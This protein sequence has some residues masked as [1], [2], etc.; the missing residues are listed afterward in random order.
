VRRITKNGK[1]SLAAGLFDFRL[2]LLVFK[3]LSDASD[4]H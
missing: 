2:R 3:K 1:L 4:F